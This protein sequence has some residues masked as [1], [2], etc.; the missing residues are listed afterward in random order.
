MKK[1]LF[2]F[3][4][5]I[6]ISAMAQKNS[7]KLGATIGNL[8]LQYE[9]AISDHF[10]IVG[11]VGFS[12]IE[13]EEIDFVGNS[14]TKDSKGLAI[15]VSPRYYFSE[16]LKGWHI[17]PFLNSINTK[18]EDEKTNLLMYGAEAGYQWVSNSGFTLG[19]SLGL[20]GF[21]VESD[22]DGVEVLNGVNLLPQIQVGIGYSF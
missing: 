11:Q 19:G 21:N 16:A 5:T 2:L 14:Y 8:G 9:R 17:G 12:K 20:A 22:I 10:S 7:V 15:Y 4:M 3:L 13:I 6:S 18:Y 1:I